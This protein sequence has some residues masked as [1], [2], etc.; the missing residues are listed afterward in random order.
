MFTEE[1][2]LKFFEDKEI[3][4]CPRW[5]QSQIIHAIERILDEEDNYDELSDESISE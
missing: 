5:R 1:Q 4:E 3:Q 2:L